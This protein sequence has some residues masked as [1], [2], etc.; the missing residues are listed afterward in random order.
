LYVLI[1]AMLYLPLQ[2]KKAKLSLCLFL[3]IVYPGREVLLCSES[4][5]RHRQNEKAKTKNGFVFL[6]FKV[7]TNIV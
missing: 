6:F 4:L 5:M 2:T 1:E 3:F 7:F